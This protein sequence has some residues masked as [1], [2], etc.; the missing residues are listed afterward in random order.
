MGR[1]LG[2]AQ[3]AKSEA[4]MAWNPFQT[5]TPAVENNVR[6]RTPQKE[7]YRELAGFAQV[8]ND[9]D[10][11]V[12]I[13]LPVGCGKSG[14]ITLAPFAFRAKRTLV[15]AP[16]VRIAQQLRDDFDPARPDMFYLKCGV[17]A[18]QPFPEPAEIRGVTT[19]R[20]DLEEA[21]V[22]ITNIQQLQG[23]ENRWLREGLVPE[24]KGNGRV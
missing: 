11:E 5:R 19:N 14:C 18:G 6:L 3:E 9:Q 8:A 10:R 22:V 1:K 20:A 12:G 21:D 15:V 2:R 17:L 16:G 23:E 13:V 7:A 24:T 4:V